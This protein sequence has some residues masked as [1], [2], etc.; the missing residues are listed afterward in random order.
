MYMYKNKSTVCPF[1]TIHL[2]TQPHALQCDD[3]KTKV[4]MEGKYEDIFKQKIPADISRTLF[5][6][7]QLRKDLV[8]E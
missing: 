4:K 5:N 6:I 2:D 7:S 3:M 1:C 8:E